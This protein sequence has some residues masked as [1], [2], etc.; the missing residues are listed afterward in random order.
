LNVLGDLIESFSGLNHPNTFKSLGLD[1][2]GF[3]VVTL[4]YEIL[5][6]HLIGQINNLASVNLVSGNHDRTSVKSDIDNMGEVVGLLAWLLE[7]EFP[8]LEVHYNPLVLTREIDGINYVLSHGHHRLSKKDA[9][10]T[11]FDY[12]SND[13][14]NLL[15]EGHLHTRQTQ[16]TYKRRVIEYEDFDFVA[17]DEMKYRKIKVAS[18]FTGN[19]YSESLGFASTAGFLLTWNNGRG[20][21]KVYDSTL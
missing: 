7:R 11:A 20:G 6:K 12:G 10:K 16:R 19:W 5:V 3:N 14:F 18:L 15:L 1:M 9:A 21:V 8:Q 4:C 17:M 13:K 2:Y